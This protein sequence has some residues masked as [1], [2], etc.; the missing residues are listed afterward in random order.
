MNRVPPAALPGSAGCCRDDR[1]AGAGPE[2]RRN[3]GFAGLRRRSSCSS[4][5]GG[6]TI[7]HQCRLE[8]YLAKMP[9][10]Q[11]AKS[12]AYFEG[13]YW[14]QL[15]DFLLTVFVMW[16]LLRFRWSLRMRDFAERITRFR[17]LQT[18]VYWVQFILAIYVLTFPMTIYEAYFREHKY[19]L[20]NQTLGP[21][22]RDQMLM[23]AVNLI[24]GRDVGD[25]V[26]GPGAQAGEKLVGVGS[27]G[28]RHHDR[29]RWIDCPGLHSSVVQQIYEVTGR[30]HQ[31]PHPQP[32]S[33]EWNPRNRCIRI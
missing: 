32:G 18:L 2:F 7:R 9:P 16:L 26:V 15:W 14:L 11:R 27:G 23:L 4:S 30:A 33:R 28:E 24:P 17:P 22:M 21:W 12:N 19:G 31:G 8:A 3:L 5:S 20:L 1:F 10:D 29:I 25:A 6:E 13:G